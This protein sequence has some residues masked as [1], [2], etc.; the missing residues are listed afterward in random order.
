RVHHSPVRQVPAKSLFSIG[1]PDAQGARL[2]GQ[3]RLAFY[4]ASA[5]R[6]LPRDRRIHRPA[7]CRVATFY[8]MAAA[9][10]SL[11]PHADDFRRSQPDSKPLSGGLDDSARDPLGDVADGPPLRLISEHSRDGP[12]LLVREPEFAIAE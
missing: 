3:S 2:R 4:V 7:A 1:R 10:A 9:P 5:G 6:Q 11:E 8:G 12:G